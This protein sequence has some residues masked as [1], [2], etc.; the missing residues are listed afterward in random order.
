MIDEKASAAER[1]HAL[2][3]HAFG[4]ELT[5][6]HAPGAAYD[7][8]HDDFD[9]Q[10]PLEA[11][12]IWIQDH[13]SL[14]SV[15]I[16]I[17]SSGTQVIFS[18]LNLRRLGE[19][20]SSHYFVVSRETLF[21]SPV[22]LTPYKSEE[23][24][25]QGAL[26]AIIDDAYN[27]AGVGPEQVDIGAVIL[28]GEA[29]RRENAEAIAGIVAERAGDFVCATAG[30]HMEAMLAAF[31][32]GAARVS[33]DSGRR[34]LNIDI[35]GG[36]TKLAIIE[37]GRVV[38]TAAF[39]V[40]GRL[41]V[42]D[43]GRIVRLDPA[44]RRLAARAGF[45]WSVGDVID[46]A[47]LDALAESMAA[48]WVSAVRDADPPADIQ[49]LYLTDRLA[50]VGPI[51]GVMFSGGVAE[52][53]YGRESRDFG[54]LG[55]R[56]GAALRRKVDAG[57][58]PWPLLPAKECIRATALG[59]SEYSV[60]LTGNTIYISNHGALLPR[61]NLQVLK[62]PCEF[63]ALI[64]PQR[65][66]EVI[67]R[68]LTLFDLAGEDKEFALAFQWRGE[69]SY[70]RIAA[71]ARGIVAGLARSI[72]R[73]Q[74]LYLI[75]DGDLAQTLGGVLRD[76]LG[77]ESEVLVIDGIVLVDFDYIDLGRIRLPSHTVPVTVKSLVFKDVPQGQAPPHQHLGRHGHH[78]HHHHN[79]QKNSGHDHH[80][81]DPQFRPRTEK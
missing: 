42:V 58:L 30:H 59:A 17:G 6:A 50:D 13:V 31:G 55:R 14:T 69:P 35:G 29:L 46:P 5:H 72:A 9:S 81:R 41:Q 54:D 63:P 79:G 49:E 23:R 20:L 25:D 32:S 34:L 77:I 74:P 4:R 48:A 78:H 80:D 38:A 28:T 76:D 40:G 7:H 44:G 60:Q 21:Q 57:E 16:D 10:G 37:S 27:M 75:L 19:D 71:F 62:P 15:G 64:D 56:L 67:Q 22:V 24:I 39:H 26:G 73:K 70:E 43:G 1:A 52:Y 12:P 65:V 47:A 45:S 33:A 11:N 51:D 66:A 36:T 8:D 18:Q 53:I 3:D 68:H 2:Q 61:R